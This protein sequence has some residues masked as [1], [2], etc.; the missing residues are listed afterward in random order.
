MLLNMSAQFALPDGFEEGAH[1]LFFAQS[2][3]LDSAVSQIAD[4]A[5]DVE[6]FRYLADGITETDPLH[7][8]FVKDL[9]R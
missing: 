8:S 9:N 5:G 7:I 4:G 2:Q 3:K 1:F 6:P